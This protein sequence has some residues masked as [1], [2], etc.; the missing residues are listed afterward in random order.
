M[1]KVNYRTIKKAN[2]TKNLRN[3]K[4][5]WKLLKN[6]QNSLANFKKNLKIN[7]TNYLKK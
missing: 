5:F 2:L 4:I 1:V 6:I 3:V 7:F